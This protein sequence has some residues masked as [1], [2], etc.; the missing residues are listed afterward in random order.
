MR[1]HRP[2]LMPTRHPLRGGKRGRV[3]GK[4]GGMDRSGQEAFMAAS[5]VNLPCPD[6][7]RLGH[8]PPQPW[9]KPGPEPPSS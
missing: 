1:G 8:S 4:P 7:G 9:Q 6:S 5:V 2:T 3:G